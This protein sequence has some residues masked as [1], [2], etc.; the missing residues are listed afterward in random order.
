M[1]RV[2]FTFQTVPFQ[3][4]KENKSCWY[5]PIHLILVDDTNV[6]GIPHAISI[7]N[8]CCHMNKRQSKPDVYEILKDSN[9]QRQNS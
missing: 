6:V 8:W 1:Q 7:S 3:A 9:F 2:A 5:L 4:Q